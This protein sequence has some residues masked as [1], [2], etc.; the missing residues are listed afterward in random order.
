[1]KI[2]Q[3]LQPKYLPNQKSNKK[4]PINYIFGRVK[5]LGIIFKLKVIAQKH[6][7]GAPVKVKITKSQ[8]IL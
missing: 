4:N 6:V 5:V 7:R 8:K 1:M 3:T 2:T